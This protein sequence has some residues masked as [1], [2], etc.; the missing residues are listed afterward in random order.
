M[1]TSRPGEGSRQSPRNGVEGAVEPGF[2]TVA[3]AFAENFTARSELG[4]AF[5]ATLDG[6]LVVDL[7]GGVADGD[8]G[9]PW[10]RDTL[11]VIFS[12]SKGLTA[13]CVAML[14]DRG[15]VALEDRV[16]RL[17]PEF[18]AQNKEAV[19]VAEIVSHRGRL[20]GVRAQL[21]EEEILDPQKMAE[22]LAAQQQDSDPRAQL[23]YH[24]FTYGWLCGELLRRVDGR[25]I[26]RFFAEEVAE[27]LGLE[28]WI[29]LPEDQ[30][31]RVARL[32]Y[33]PSWGQD[34]IGRADPFPGDAL[35]ARIWQNPCLFQPPSP[36]FWNTRALHATE[37]P[38]VNAVGTA[39]SLARLYGLLSRDGELDGVRLLSAET[40]ELAQTELSSGE[41]A[42]TGEQLAFGVGFMLQTGDAPFGPAQRAFGHGGAGGSCHGAWPE[43]R[44]GFSYAMNEMRDDPEGDPRVSALL[45]ALYSCVQARPAD[46][47]GPD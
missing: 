10:R 27:P 26:G 34:P 37:M 24:P 42:F 32:Q 3:E 6:R 15:L 7:W 35:W 8:S 11:Q 40:L 43:H 30:E 23:I 25:S 28:L 12:G 31:P 38:A 45:D 2:A 1:A 13:L 17:W 39:R 29:G 14:I 4:A 9:S 44:V 47:Q 46:A 19:T 16:S 41:E 22:L 20:P 36:E 33:G 18:S 5:A 21:K